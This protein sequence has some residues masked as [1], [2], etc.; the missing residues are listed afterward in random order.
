VINDLG[1]IVYGGMPNS[2]STPP[3]RTS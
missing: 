3:Y 1:D 2:N